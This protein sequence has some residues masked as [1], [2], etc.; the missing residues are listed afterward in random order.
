MTLG[1]VAEFNPFLEYGFPTAEQKFLAYIKK[2]NRGTLNLV[3]R[4]RLKNEMSL[5]SFYTSSS[6]LRIKAFG[7]NKSMKLHWLVSRERVSNSKKNVRSSP[8]RQGHVVPLS[9]IVKNFCRCHR[10]LPSSILLKT[11]NNSVIRGCL[12]TRKH[13]FL[14]HVMHQTCLPKFVSHF[15]LIA[16]QANGLVKNTR[17]NL[18]RVAI[19]ST[20]KKLNMY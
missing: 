5:N 9:L 18:D 20:V 4:E 15:Q 8:Q 10:N 3:C 7:L 17:S 14:L 16:N 19:A 2:L 6:P 1:L 11:P 12:P 13:N